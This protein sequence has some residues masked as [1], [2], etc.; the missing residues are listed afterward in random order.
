MADFWYPY[1]DM[2]DARRRLCLLADRVAK[3]GCGV[4]FCDGSRIAV[5]RHPTGSTGTWMNVLVRHVAVPPPPPPP[6]GIMQKI[7]QWFEKALAAYGEAELQRSQAEMAASREMTKLFHDDVWLPAHQFLVRHKWAADGVAVAADV[8]GIVAFVGLILAAPE[9]IA[10]GTAL[11]IAALVTG[12]LAGDACI[13]LLA[14]DGAVFVTE[15]SANE[16]FSRMIEEDATIQKIRIAAT[17]FLLPDLP[18]GGM[19]ALAEF[20]ALGNEAR[21]GAALAGRLEEG[22]EAER[23]RAASVSHP[24][25]H[26][27]SVQRYRHKANVLARQAEEER[28]E[29]AQIQ[30]K[31]SALLHFELGAVPAG[32]AASEALLGLSPPSMLMNKEDLEA[33]EKIVSRQAMPEGGIPKGVRLEIFIGAEQKVEAH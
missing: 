20:R 3:P 32:T 25:K 16:A 17:L 27:H 24:R 28:L 6:D 4:S 33:D 30:R 7:E 11:G 10:A 23:A 5:L 26:L 22:A 8:I 14:V 9:I 19:R 21:E 29:V 13:A 2:D 1:A 18:V 31:M 12:T 15:V